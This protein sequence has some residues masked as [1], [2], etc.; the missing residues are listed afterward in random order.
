[1]LKEESMKLQYDL[2]LQYNS[3]VQQFLFEDNGEN[4][5]ENKKM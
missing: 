2:I 3:I 5:G 4:E 1:M